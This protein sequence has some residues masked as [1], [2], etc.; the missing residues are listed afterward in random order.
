MEESDKCESHPKEGIRL[1]CKEEGCDLQPLCPM[2]IPEHFKHS[3]VN[4]EEYWEEKLQNIDSANIEG[5]ELKEEMKDSNIQQKDNILTTCRDM[6]KYILD[7]GRKLE[8][9]ISRSISSDVKSMVKSINNYEEKIINNIRKNHLDLENI[10]EY[11]E[12]NTKRR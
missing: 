8:I 5:E 12:E 6:K 11:G 7:W 10:I 4:I 1:I 2:C 3:I 9:K